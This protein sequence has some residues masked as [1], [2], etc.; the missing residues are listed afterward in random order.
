MFIF[1]MPS[2]LFLAALWS[3]AGKGLTSWLCSCILVTL[4]YGVPGQVC[5][6][7]VSIPDLC[8]P[9]CVSHLSKDHFFVTFDDDT[10]PV[11]STEGIVA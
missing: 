2:C 11:H 8:I 1:D 5:F 10:V 6:L 3:P 7:I 4:P 9:L